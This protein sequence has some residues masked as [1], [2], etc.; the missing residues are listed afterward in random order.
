MTLG[1]NSSKVSARTREDRVDVRKVGLHTLSSA[2]QPDLVV[3][4]PERI[5]RGLPNTVVRVLF[6]SFWWSLIPF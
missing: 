1:E 4:S 3:L 6:T 5:R 2:V